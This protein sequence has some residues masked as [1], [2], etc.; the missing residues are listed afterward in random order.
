MTHLTKLALLSVSLLV[1]SG[2]AIAANMPEM[3]NSY[4]EI[5]PMWIELLTTMPSLFIILT[6]PFSPKIAKRLGY[7]ATVQLGLLC[8]LGAGIIPVISQSFSLLFFSRML[9]GIG[10]GLFNPLLYTLATTL[11]SGPEKSAVIGLQSS[12]EGIGGMVVT[13][14]VGQLLLVHWRISF[15]SYLITI[16]V[17]ILFTL[18]VPNVSLEAPQEVGAADKGQVPPITYG[19]LSLLVLLVTIYM[20]FTVKITSLLLEKNI[21]SPTDGSNL[22]ALVGLGAMLAGMLFGVILKVTKKW[23]LP[24]SFLLLAV[25]MTMVGYAEQLV[26]VI[27]AAI[28]CG[29]SFRT[30][31]PY[32]FN[33]VNKEGQPNGEKSTSLLLIAFNLGA[34]FT[35]ISLAFIEGSLS[36]KSNSDLFILEALCLFILSIGGFIHQ[37]W[38]KKRQAL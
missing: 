21:G 16:P 23:T 26:T 2:G 13:F 3:I 30:F 1:V 19:Y 20:S 36:L 29:F 27:L 8:V 11:Y 22:M 9:F 33:E 37:L 6:I 28:L 7:K 35:P 31:I 14:M 25:A 24:L 4:P 34:A 38:H 32:I 12:F 18:F 17:F 5:Q 10:V 15:L